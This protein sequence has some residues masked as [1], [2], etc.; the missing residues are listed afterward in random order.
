VAVGAYGTNDAIHFNI[1]GAGVQSIVLSAALAVTKPVIIDGYTQ[2]LTSANTNGPGQG[3]NAVLLVELRYNSG[4]L[5]IAGGN[6]AVQGLVI[7]GV[8]G[9]LVLTG[10]GGNTVTGNFIGTDATGSAAGPHGASPLID[11]F[12]NTTSPNNTIGGV[13]PAARNLISG[14]STGASS[15]PGILIESSGNTVQGNLIGTNAAGTA[16]LANDIG[17]NIFFGGANNNVIGGTTAGARNIISGNRLSGIE[18][19]TSGHTVQATAFNVKP[20][21]EVST[22]DWP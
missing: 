7:N 6:S 17:I 5:N 16:A 21:W 12:V 1:P 20:P 18:M 8:T 3:T 15:N 10:L 13:T 19:D 2:P 22:A 14:A 9:T 11:I 4:N